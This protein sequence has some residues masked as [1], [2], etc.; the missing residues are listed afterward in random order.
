[1]K[2]KEPCG[3]CYAIGFSLILFVVII[4]IADRLLVI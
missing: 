3:I 1:M 2:D 4:E